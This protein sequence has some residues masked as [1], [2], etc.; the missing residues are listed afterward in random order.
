VSILY[1]ALGLFIGGFLNLAADHL[2]RDRSPFSVPTC[3]KCGTS[4]SWRE[5]GA[6]ARLLG[7]TWKCPECGA[8][9]KIRRP[10]LALGTAVAFAFF[11]LRYGFSPELFLVSLY[12][13]A[14]FL[15]FVIDLEHRLIL[16]VVVYPAILL[17]LAGSHFYP[18][19]G[20]RRAIVGGAVAFVFFYLVAVLGRLVF[21]RTAMGGGDA[22]LAALVGLMTGF[23]DVIVALLVTVCLGGLVSLGLVIGGIRGLRSYIPYG[24]FLA[25]GGLIVLVFGAE[26]IGWY[27]SL[28]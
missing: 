16:R 2:P 27:F 7:I 9:T 17:A 10:A 25:A 26:I 20:L 19:L 3:A 13:C 18:G 28:F 12:S 6:W 5:R 1:G 15:I 22:N 23:P 8:G 14:L 11:W 4:W 21:R 24:I